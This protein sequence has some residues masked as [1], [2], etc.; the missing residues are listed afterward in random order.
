MQPENLPP[1]VQRALDE[2]YYDEYPVRTVI[3]ENAFVLSWYFLAGLGFW[4]IKLFGL[5]L[6][7]YAY[8]LT[9]VFAH[10]YF[11]RKKACTNCLYYGKRC[12]LGWGLYTAKLFPRGDVKDFEFCTEEYANTYWRVY[13]FYV[14]VAVM[15][16]TLFLS[17]SWLILVNLIVYFALLWTGKA[18]MRDNGCVHCKMRYLCP[19][20]SFKY[21]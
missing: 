19:L 13:M 1:E 3:V 8:W 2:H 12:H 4:E 15:L 7:S 5:H 21:T 11:L 14:P 20:S 9:V 17:F 16:T 10:G 6:F 18:Y